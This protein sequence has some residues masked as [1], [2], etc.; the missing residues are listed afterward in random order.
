MENKKE[1]TVSLPWFGIPRLWPYVRPYR[2]KIVLMVFF[3]ILSSLIDA[4]YPLFNRYI[5]N[6]TVGENKPDT[7]PVVIVLYLSVLQSDHHF[8]VVLFI[9]KR[10]IKSLFGFRKRE[11][12][13]NQALQFDLSGGKGIH[14]HSVIISV[15]E[16]RTDLNL[17][18]LNMIKIKGDFL[19]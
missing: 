17:A 1:K 13:R 19:M 4:V 7:L 9:M 6:V 15:T 3:G 16:N 12:R 14:R 10:R 11:F 2:W 18:F 5:L 8:D